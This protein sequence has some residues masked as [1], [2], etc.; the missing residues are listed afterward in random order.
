M[1]NTLSPQMIEAL[2]AASIATF[3][4]G[5]D[6]AARNSPTCRHCDRPAAPGYGNCLTCCEEVGGDY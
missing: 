4:S 3:N 6:A 2:K 5:Y 1:T